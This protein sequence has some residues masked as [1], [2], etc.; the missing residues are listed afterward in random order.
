MIAAEDMNGRDWEDHYNVHTLKV[1]ID[2]RGL[3]FHLFGWIKLALLDD[4]EV[5]K[6]VKCL[7]SSVER[8]DR[9]PGQAGR[10]GAAVQVIIDRQ[11]ENNRVRNW[12]KCPLRTS[13]LIVGGTSELPSWFIYMAK[14]LY[15]IWGILYREI[16][17]RN[18]CNWTI[19]GWLMGTECSTRTPTD[20]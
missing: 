5:L 8:P 15:W 17:I 2:H 19:S 20:F 1:T 10:Q 16:W 3:I 13:W 9:W 18:R 7:D 4:I 6:Y 14:R 12:Y 11:V